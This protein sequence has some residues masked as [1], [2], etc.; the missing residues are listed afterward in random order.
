MH[1]FLRFVKFCA[2]LAVIRNSVWIAFLMILWS[3]LDAHNEYIIFYRIGLKLM[4]FYI[5][6]STYAAYKVFDGVRKVKYESVN[7]NIHKYLTFHPSLSNP[8]YKLASSFHRKIYL[9]L[10][11]FFFSPCSFNILSTN[12]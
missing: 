1:S 8:Y 10:N 5:I 7:G 11:S 4:E 3:L 6:W 9:I 2:I 12:R